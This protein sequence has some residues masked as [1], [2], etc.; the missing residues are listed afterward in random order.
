MTRRLIS[1][2]RMRKFPTRDF[3]DAVAAANDRNQYGNRHRPGRRPDGVVSIH[4]TRDEDAFLEGQPIGI[5]G[6][7]VEHSDN[8]PGFFRMPGFSGVEPDVL[9]HALKWVIADEKIEAG[10]IGNAVYRGMCAAQV[11]IRNEHHT[12]ARFRTDGDTEAVQL[13]SDFGGLATIVAKPNGTGDHWCQLD[14]RADSSWWA[15]GYLTGTLDAAIAAGTKVEPET[16]NVRVWQRDALGNMATDTEW[17]IEAWNV[18]EFTSALEDFYAR[19]RF[20]GTF[21]RIDA[22]DCDASGLEGASG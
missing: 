19:L 16:V 12:H 13:W 11:D 22:L 10:R 1:G 6:L 15:E 5:D 20:D 2:Q 18:S 9:T 7:L 21:W 14:M 3:N 17:E 4:N 8:E